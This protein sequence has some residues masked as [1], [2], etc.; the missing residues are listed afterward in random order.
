MKTYY[1]MLLLINCLTISYAIVNKIWIALIVPVPTALALL[2]A[3]VV[4]I[5]DSKKTENI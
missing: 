4:L 5:N 2:I 1:T 3:L